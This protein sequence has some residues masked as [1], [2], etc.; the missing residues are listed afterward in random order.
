MKCL[1][2]ILV[3]LLLAPWPVSFRLNLQGEAY[4]RSDDKTGEDADH[5]ASVGSSIISGITSTKEPAY[6]DNSEIPKLR[7]NFESDSSNELYFRLFVTPEDPSIETLAAQIS[8]PRD[9]YQIAVQWIYISDSKLNQVADKWLTPHEF[10]TNTPNYPTNPLQGKAVSDCEEKANA[11]VSLIRAKG[12]RPEEVRVALGKVTIFNAETGHA[13]IELLTNGYWLALDPCWGPY[14]DDRA[15]KLVSRQ[16]VPFD[17][18]SSHAYPA[19][20]VWTYYNDVYY[21]DV[22]D[23]SGNAP[24]SWGG[25]APAKL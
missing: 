23:G 19:T 3:I 20:Q 7:D 18:Y 24:T 10:L 17:Y 15:E 2:A 5:I 16:G 14:W 13:W 4:V 1:F 9:A 12:V 8:G 21:L 25:T 6:R 11:L 22:R